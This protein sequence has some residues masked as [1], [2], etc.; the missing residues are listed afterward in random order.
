VPVL[1]RT[2][3]HTNQR[4]YVTYNFDC[5]VIT[6]RL[7]GSR[8]HCKNGYVLEMVQDRKEH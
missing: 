7:V 3:L 6:E 4:A 2:C 8:V 1:A 5:H